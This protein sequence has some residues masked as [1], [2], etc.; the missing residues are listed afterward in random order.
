MICI[1]LSLFLY[2]VPSVIP[3][4]SFCRWFVVAVCSLLGKC[5]V[6]NSALPQN[7]AAFYCDVIVAHEAASASVVDRCLWW[8]GRYFK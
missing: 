2:V 3:L 5:L 8:S 4:Q 6:Q 1:N 7:V